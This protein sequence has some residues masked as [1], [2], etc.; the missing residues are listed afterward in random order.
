MEISF[1]G[2]LSSMTLEDQLNSSCSLTGKAWHMW[3][4][5]WGL[6]WFPLSQD[7]KSVIRDHLISQGDSM[8]GKEPL[9]LS[10]PGNTLCQKMSSSTEKVPT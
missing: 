2:K 6:L 9:N 7:I 8:A 10:D 5:V 4:G 3:S 1:I